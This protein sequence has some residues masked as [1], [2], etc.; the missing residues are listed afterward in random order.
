MDTFT[1]LPG[2]TDLEPAA[3]FNRLSLSP[4][5]DLKLD[6][7][8]E[9]SVSELWDE[10]DSITLPYGIASTLLKWYQKE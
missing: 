4:L 3:L 7:Y 1:E 2:D 8:G 5:V 10:A 9:E 6:T